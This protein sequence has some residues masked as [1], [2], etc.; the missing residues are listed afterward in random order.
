MRIVPGAAVLIAAATLFGGA[1]VAATAPLP[2]RGEEAW[3]FASLDLGRA[4]E[5]ATG[6]GVTLA[7]IDGPIA[8][9]VPELRGRDV[10]A[11][12]N[13]CGGAAT[14]TGEVADH[15]TALA[16]AI[17]GNGK[18]NAP[19][20]VGTSGVAPEATLRVYAVGSSVDEVGCGRQ[21]VDG[22]ALAIE[23]AV[24]DGVRIIGYAGGSE[25]L[26][27]SVSAAVQRALDAGIVVVA[28][29]GDSRDDAVLNPAAIPG[30]VAVAATTRDGAGWI[31]N[32]AGNRAAFVVSAPGV[33]LPMGGFFDGVWR[34]AALRSGTSEATAIVM[35]ALALAMQRWPDAT[36]NQIL[37]N[38]LRTATG[39][40][41]SA[42]LPPSP[43]PFG[44]DT[45]LGFGVVSVTGMLAVD[46][47]QWP[48]L[49]PLRPPAPSPTPRPLVAEG[50]GVGWA[51]PLGAV[52]GTAG[53]VA[54]FV[55]VRVRPKRQN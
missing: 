7:L 10:A 24:D 39:R 19:D 11:V 48:D 43:A 23:R 40:T 37:T 1:A 49:N 20:G 27:P 18:G 31:E 21:D 25:R 35:G 3:W 8:L 5:Q 12:T 45:D 46:P 9:K 41:V 32:T 6:K 2:P 44:R 53:F 22:A 38:L 30:V 51:L 52:L 13:V 54:V 33:D 36:G 28:A 16:V 15:T 42:R 17:V 55:V 50:G 26:R 29:A 4:R 34:S 47:Q 14:A